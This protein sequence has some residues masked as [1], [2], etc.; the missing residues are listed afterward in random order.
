[1][2]RRLQNIKTMNTSPYIPHTSSDIEE[3]LHVIGKESIAELFSGIPEEIRRRAQEQWNLP[4]GLSEQDVLERLNELSQKNADDQRYSSFLGAGVYRHFVPSVIDQLLL[5]G[6]FLT[7]Y[8]PYQP[9]ISQGNLQAIFE[10]Q[11]MVCLLTGLD[12]S[13]AGL[14]DGATALLEAA[15]L[16]LRVKKG[17]KQVL[18]SAALA[19]KVKAVLSSVLCPNGFQLKEIAYDAQTGAVSAK[20]LQQ[21]LQS[22]EGVAC[23]C[24]GY[25]NYFGVLEPL[26][27]LSALVHQAGALSIAYT[28]EVLALSVYRAP[29]ELG[30]DL[31]V[32]DMQSF[33]IAPNFG[34]PSCGFLAAKEEFMRQLPGRL[35]GETVDH[36][37]QRGFVLTL[38]TREQHIRREKATSN[39]CTNH[40][41][42]ALASTIYL[43]LLG[44]QGLRE[45]GELNRA[46]T[47]YLARELEKLGLQ[48]IFNGPRFNEL[49]LSLENAPASWRDPEKLLSK[50]F[51]EHKILFG[52]ALVEQFPELKYCL[53]L[54]VTELNSRR[55]LD[56]LLAVLRLYCCAEK[57]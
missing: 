48:L 42:M 37:G 22:S 25:P 56:E 4:A 24:L 15:L 44:P 49:V 23:V 16:A 1:M 33:G 53:L 3:M 43:A 21:A 26:E 47:E 17:S 9:E 11:S 35:V 6:E 14:Y 5:R 10:F 32:G 46:R 19:A 45:L 30:V 27:E 31:S 28:P 52:T 41:L 29:G 12:V 55:A 7:S 34:G 2:W 36:N 51:Q 38:A 8:T 20:S 57:Q 50:L 54:S 18:I 40:A 13:N 39:I